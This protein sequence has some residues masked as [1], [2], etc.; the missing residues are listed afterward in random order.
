[1]TSQAL[2]LCLWLPAL[3]LSWEGNLV[4]VGDMGFGLRIRVP[5]TS[6]TGREA[7]GDILELVFSTV[8]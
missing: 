5:F 2:F 7:V 4:C 1:M 6:L 8:K 3:E